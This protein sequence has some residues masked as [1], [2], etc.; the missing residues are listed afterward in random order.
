MTELRS[1]EAEC[2]AVWLNE[3]LRALLHLYQY[4]AAT[5]AGPASIPEL[6]KVLRMIDNDL[7]AGKE[8]PTGF[9]ARPDL[10]KAVGLDDV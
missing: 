8:L 9:V 2:T 10:E 5:D 4:M 7:D 3:V 6:P 1:D